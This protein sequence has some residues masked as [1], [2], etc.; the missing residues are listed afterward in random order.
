MARRLFSQSITE[1][2]AF[3]DMPLTAQGLYFH[4]GMNADDDGFVSPRKIMRM[5]GA[6]A[7]DLRVLIAKRFVL[8]FDSGVV[9]IKHWLINNSIRRDRYHATTWQKELATLT[10]N[11]FGSYTEK[12]NFQQTL[13]NDISITTS[14]SDE[15]A[16][17]QPNDNQMETEVKLSKAKLSKV[18]NINTTDVVLAEKSPTKKTPSKNIDLLFDYWQEQIGYAITSKRQANRF[19]CSNLIKKF[20]VE[21]V[22]RLVDGVLQAQGDRYGPKISDFSD[23]QSNLNKLLAWGRNHKQKGL[24]KI[25]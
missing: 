14:N 25:R 7:D 8:S 18:N 15:D 11:E 19:A 22:K 17:K 21:D 6:N 1:T 4:L 9:V 24:V 3:L 10:T 20:G 2:D 12:R 23:L 16:L 5:V 13:L